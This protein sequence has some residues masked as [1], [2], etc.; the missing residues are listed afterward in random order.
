MHGTARHAAPRRA[1]PCHAASRHTTAGASCHNTFKADVHRHVCRH[2]HWRAYGHVCVHTV[3]Q[4]HQLAWWQRRRRQERPL[5]GQELHQLL[6]NPL[7]SA[8]LLAPT[9][10]PRTYQARRPASSYPASYPAIYPASYPAS[11]QVTPLAATQPVPQPFT[12]PF[13]Q[14]RYPAALCILGAE[15][16]CRC[17][18]TV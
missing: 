13:T 5:P 11:Y 18:C 9:L 1:T 4:I 2:M 8:G 10:A 12:Q 15:R 17:S 7:R 6:D 14:L 3:D 16:F